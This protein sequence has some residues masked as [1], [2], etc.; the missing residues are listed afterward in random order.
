MVLDAVFHIRSL[1]GRLTFSGA[2]VRGRLP[3]VAGEPGA[4]CLCIA[5]RVALFGG[6]PF[7]MERYPTLCPARGSCRCG[8]LCRSLRICPFTRDVSQR[9]GYSLLRRRPWREV[10][11]CG[12]VFPLRRCLAAGSRWMLCAGLRIGIRLRALT[13]W[14]APPCRVFPLRAVPCGRLAVDAMRGFANRNPVAGDALRRAPSADA[15][16]PYLPLR[17]FPILEKGN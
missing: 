10:L 13:L 4:K 11:P 17:L 1:L 16:F 7:V 8:R 12:R 14:Q 6:A 2:R 5:R 3:G 9:C 15:A